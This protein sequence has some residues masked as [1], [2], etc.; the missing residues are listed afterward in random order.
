MDFVVVNNLKTTYYRG[1]VGRQHLLFVHGWASS[2]RM[3]L[4]SMWALRR[5][6]HMWAVDLPGCGDS[7]RPDPIWFS[8]EHYT[9]HIAAFCEALGINPYAVIGHSLGGRVVL[10]FARRYR[11]RVE[12]VVAISPSVTGRLGFNLDVFLVG[13]LLGSTMKLLRR[14]WPIATAETMSLYW[15]PRYLGTEVVARTTADLRRTSW[16][17][18]TASLRALVRQDFSPNLADVPHPTL[19]IHGQRDFTVPPEDSRIAA[20]C[21]RDARVLELRGVHHQPTDEAP[22]AYLDAVKAFLA[23]GYVGRP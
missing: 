8:I 12:K 15:A 9:D 16:E 18:A 2:G 1:G 21:L 5:D 23:N 20:R 4:R 11:E 3:W 13:G 17:A 10:D 22:G 6:Y 19:L 14:I 7:D